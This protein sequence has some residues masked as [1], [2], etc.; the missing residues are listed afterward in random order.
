VH[1]ITIN[2]ARWHS[3]TQVASEGRR[4]QKH[5]YGSVF[6]D[7]GLATTPQQAS[8]V[9]L[10]Y[11]RQQFFCVVSQSLC[12]GAPTFHAC[13]TRWGMVPFFTE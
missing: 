7:L 6:R 8:K 12:A 5:G 4:I 13:N 11:T 10:L 1:H 2:V 9:F 3:E